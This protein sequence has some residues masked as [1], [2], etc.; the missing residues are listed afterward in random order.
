MIEIEDNILST[1]SITL[2]T[3]RTILS[4]ILIFTR[5]STYDTNRIKAA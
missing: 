1:S 5:F 2:G 3:E 4:T